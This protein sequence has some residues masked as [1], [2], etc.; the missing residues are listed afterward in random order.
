MG[1]KLL[2]VECRQLLHAGSFTQAIAARCS[3]KAAS[4]RRKWTKSHVGE[5]ARCREA[6]VET[7]KKG[8][9]PAKCRVAAARRK[10]HRRMPRSSSSDNQPSLS[11][12]VVATEALKM[13]VR[14]KEKSISLALRER[15][16]GRGFLFQPPSPQSLRAMWL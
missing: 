11:S 1:R 5:A 9:Q 3:M 7:G 15:E 2:S 14:L 16:R 8:R 13:M 12:I 10:T 4:G 6:H